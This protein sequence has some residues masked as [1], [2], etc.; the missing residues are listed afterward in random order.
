MRKK[1]EKKY[2]PRVHDV[3]V[4]LN[5]RWEKL[6]RNEREKAIS[7]GFDQESW[8]NNYCERVEVKGDDY[9]VHGDGSHVRM[10]ILV[11]D[12]ARRKEPFEFSGDLPVTGI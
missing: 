5:N 9:Y 6:T 7:L 11:G 10:D 12:R 8:N 1:R 2:R 3:P 4:V